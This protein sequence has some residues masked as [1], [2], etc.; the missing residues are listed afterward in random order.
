MQ[1]LNIFDRV[2]EFLN[3]AGNISKIL[4]YTYSI[5]LDK[6]HA[7]KAKVFWENSSEDNKLDDDEW[8]E[9]LPP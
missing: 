2:I 9:N 5:L 7:E 1:N 6:C 3:L 4:K 8:E